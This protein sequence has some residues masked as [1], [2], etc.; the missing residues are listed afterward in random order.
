MAKQ[1]KESKHADKLRELGFKLYSELMSKEDMADIDQHFQ[2]Q[3]GFLPHQLSWAQRRRLQRQNILPGF[4]I[5]NDGATVYTYA[6]DEYGL[7]WHA[8]GSVDLA[9]FGFHS[10]SA[11][12][13]KQYLGMGLQKN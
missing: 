7:D 8:D 4:F 9:P 11:E 10:G 13:L 2:K 1:P 3:V 6:M 5:I 12:L